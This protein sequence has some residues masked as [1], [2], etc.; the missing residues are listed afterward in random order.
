MQRSNHLLMSPRASTEILRV[1]SIRSPSYQREQLEVI[2]GPQGPPGTRDTTARLRCYR[3][4]RD[5]LRVRAENET[6]CGQPHMQGPV[7]SACQSSKKRLLKPQKWVVCHDE[8]H[9]SQ[10]RTSDRAS[11]WDLQATNSTYW[12]VGE[13][14]GV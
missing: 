6:H 14:T 2:T 9:P 3:G 13:G 11:G 7:L 5:I 12:G 10:L 1:G 8:S 4:T